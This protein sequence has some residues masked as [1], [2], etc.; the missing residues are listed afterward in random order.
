M[1]D[2]TPVDGAPAPSTGDRRLRA[3]VLGSP[4]AHSKSPALHRAAYAGLGLDWAYDAV[5]VD[6]AGLA[7]F[8]G[9]LGP[10]WAGLSLTMPLKQTVIPLLDWLD[11][12]AAA[13]AAVNTVVLPGAPTFDGTVRGYN[14]DVEGIVAAVQPLLADRP[15]S[16]VILGSGATARSAAAAAVDLGARHIDVV[17]RRR[18]AAEDVAR[19]AAELGSPATSALDLSDRSAVQS[20]FAAADLVISTLPAGAGESV[21]DLELA[22]GGVLLDVVYAPW[23]TALAR[24][25][26]GPVAPGSEMLLL[27]AVA[28]VRL[29][30]GLDPDVDLM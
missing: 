19:I 10:E 11:P 17:A 2:A 7:A 4:I 3:A 28:Q 13:S 1:N 8:M 5:E 9:G 22:G 20:C 18:A 12:R 27:Q 26:D 15:E 23:P 6:E 30:T 16:V 21:A 29:M 25:W 24:S 14:T